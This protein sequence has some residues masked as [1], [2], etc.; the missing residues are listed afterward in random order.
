MITIL[1]GDFLGEGLRDI[2]EPRLKSRCC[3]VRKFARSENHA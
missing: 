1:G 3:R 2:L